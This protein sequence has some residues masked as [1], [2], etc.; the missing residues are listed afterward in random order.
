MVGFIDDHRETFGVEPICVVLPIDP[1]RYYELK[2]R[3]R[4]PDRRP[5]RRRGETRDC[6]TTS[7]ACGGRIAGLRRPQSLEAAPA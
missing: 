1:S 5:Q 4:D 6:A 3:D 7:V 2:A